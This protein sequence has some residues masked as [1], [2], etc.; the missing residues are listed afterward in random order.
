MTTFAG[1]IVMRC[2]LAALFTFLGLPV[3]W[4]YGALIGD[5]LLKGLMLTIRFH[6]GRWQ[7]LMSSEKMGI[8]VA[9]N[10]NT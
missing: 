4:V 2:G 8:R 7:T 5:Y 3:I 9:C 6:G 10:E 1:L